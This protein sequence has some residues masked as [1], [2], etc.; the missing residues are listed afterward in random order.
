MEVLM[1][2]GPE[3]MGSSYVGSVLPF[4]SCMKRVMFL[5]TGDESWCKCCY[6]LMQDWPRLEQYSV[7]GN[8]ST[9]ISILRITGFQNL[10]FQPIH[11]HPNRTT[12]HSALAGAGTQ[13]R[14]MRATLPPTP[15]HLLLDHWVWC[16]YHWTVER[17]LQLLLAGHGWLVVWVHFARAELKEALDMV[18][19]L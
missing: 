8:F 6:E 16:Y 11:M 13:L 1:V 17:V 2:M 3:L 7:Q 18:C 14:A 12:M 19:P 5:S 9:T 10:A 15:T 4:T